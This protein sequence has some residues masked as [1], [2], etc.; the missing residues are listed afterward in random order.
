MFPFVYLKFNFTLVR[1]PTRNALGFST[2]QKNV[3]SEKD[4]ERQKKKDRDGALSAVRFIRNVLF[5]GRKETNTEI[6]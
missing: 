2:A 3:S 6:K 4:P 1:F 5:S